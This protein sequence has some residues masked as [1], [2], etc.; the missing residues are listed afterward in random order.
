MISSFYKYFDVDFSS[1]PKFIGFKNS[2]RT[3]KTK[4]SIKKRGKR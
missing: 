1:K 3:K 4:K 2:K